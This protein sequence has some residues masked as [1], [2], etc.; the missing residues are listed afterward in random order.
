MAKRILYVSPAAPEASAE[1]WET[2]P[3]QE[4]ERRVVAGA[5]L[6]IGILDNNK[7]NADHLLAFLVE[8]L[9]DQLPVASVVSARKP[10]ASSPAEPHVLDG[11]WKEADLVVS[12][13]AD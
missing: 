1:T 11:L 6:R 13:M 10:T 12:A 4:P 9:R 8:G 5:G 7:A 3:A 2:R